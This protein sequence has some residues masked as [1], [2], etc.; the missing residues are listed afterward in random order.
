MLRCW[1]CRR[2]SAMMTTVRCVRDPVLTAWRILGTGVPVDVDEDD[3]ARS[4][5]RSSRRCVNAKI[6]VEARDDLAMM[7]CSISA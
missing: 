2:L 3:P 6:G 5:T 4:M 7:Q 1:W